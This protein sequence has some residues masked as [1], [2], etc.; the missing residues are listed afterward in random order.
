MLRL[1]KPDAQAAFKR[2]RADL[3]A[4]GIEVRLTETM[5]SSAKQADLFREGTK[6]ANKVSWHQLGRA[7]HE[8][9]IDPNTGKLDIAAK[10]LDLWRQRAKLAEKHGIRQLG[11]NADGTV[12]Y[13]KTPKGKAFDPYHLEFRGKHPTLVAAVEAEAPE[14]KSLFTS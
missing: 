1:L 9:I 3:N 14:L 2:Y 10:C 11:F 7:W 6:T 12:R 4:A 13:I 8:I 5:R